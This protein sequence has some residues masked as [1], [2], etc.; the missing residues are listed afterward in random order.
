ME[1]SWIFDVFDLRMEISWALNLEF[2][3][4]FSEG[5]HGIFNAFFHGIF[6]MKT[7]KKVIKLVK[8]ISWAIKNSLLM[9]FSP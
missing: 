1:F 4:E 8:E 7:P 3:M 6:P 5:F 9:G 2:L